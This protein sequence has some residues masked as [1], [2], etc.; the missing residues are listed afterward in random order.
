MQLVFA[1]H[2]KHK[3]EEICSLLKNRASLLNLNDLGIF[4]EIEETGKTLKE[5][6]QLKAKYIFERYKLN[7]FADDTGLE[8][9]ALNGDPGVYSARFAGNEKNASKNVEKLLKIMKNIE[10]R[11][12]CFKTIIALYYENNIHYF[13][14]TVE[15]TIL[16]KPIG[17]KGFGY[18]P[19]FMPKGYNKSFA[20]MN[21]EIKNKISHRAI[22]IE[23]LVD[24]FSLKN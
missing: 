14:G 22:A 16:E 7:V 11:Q 3:F 20:Q 1:T 9:D 15:G 10:N 4:E 8:V 12:A 5:N 17:N 18:D 6:A 13:E 2:N 23:K 21:I 24:F 19:V